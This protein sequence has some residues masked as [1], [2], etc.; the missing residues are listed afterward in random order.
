MTRGQP[1]LIP[2]FNN[3]NNLLL[4]NFIIQ[5]LTLSQEFKELD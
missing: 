1:M 3:L 4:L 2:L 5:V